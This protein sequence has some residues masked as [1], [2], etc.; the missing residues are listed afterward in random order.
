MMIKIFFFIFFV[1]EIIFCQQCYNYTCADIDS[2]LCEKRI[3]NGTDYNFLLQE[4]PH[5]FK[6]PFSDGQSSISCRSSPSGDLPAYPGGRCSRDSDCLSGKCNVTCAGSDAG[7]TCSNSRDCLFGLACINKVCTAL[8]TKGVAC[9]SELECKFNMTCYKNTCTEYFT[10]DDGKELDAQDSAYLCK[11]GYSYNNICRSLAN[12]DSEIKNCDIKKPCNYTDSTGNSFSINSCDCGYNQ[13]GSTQCMLG[14]LNNTDFSNFIDDLKKIM[15]FGNMCNAEEL[16]FKY[17]RE[18]T[19]NDWDIKKEVIKNL[20]THIYAYANHQLINSDY[21]V[22]KVVFG[23]D[24]TPP[25]P[26]DGKWQ[27]PQ[28]KCNSNISY[29]INQTDSNVTRRDKVCAYSENPFN[30]KGENATIYFRPA[31]KSGESCN[32]Q[33]ELVLSNW[34]SKHY[35]IKNSDFSHDRKKLPGEKCSSHNSCNKGSFSDVGY[36]IDGLCSGRKENENCTLHEDCVAGTFCNGLRCEKQQNTGMFCIDKYHCANQLGCLNNTCT[37][38]FSQTNATYLSKDSLDNNLCKD[39][40]INKYT[41]QCSIMIYKNHTADSNGFV[42]CNNGDTCFYT[43]GFYVNGENDTIQ[44][45]CECGYN[46]EG[47][48]YCPRPSNY[49]KFN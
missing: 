47:Q 3:S 20:K 30:E 22:P 2:K 44:M 49:S 18:Y 8:K 25:Q 36:C 12:S 17:C 27:C 46:E 15:N 45:N 48:G 5:N 38:L 35:C 41:N 13:Q 33:P 11:S 14:T 37:A 31:C 39:G 28:F 9:N 4:C 23:W 40:M 42:K 19:R 34:T 10:L 32:Y 1:F 43:T 29:V 21:C 7:E 24:D 16:R 6:C 26:R